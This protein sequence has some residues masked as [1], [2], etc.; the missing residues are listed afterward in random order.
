[1]SHKLGSYTLDICACSYYIYL[2]IRVKSY[3]R[4]RLAVW[5]CLIAHLENRPTSDSS[6]PR[7]HRFL[8]AHHRQA[9]QRNHR[10]LSPPP[11]PRRPRR[12]LRHST[13]G[14]A[15]ARGIAR[16][17]APPPLCPPPLPRD[18]HGKVGAT[19]SRPPLLPPLHSFLWQAFFSAPTERL[20]YSCRNPPCLRSSDGLHRPRP[21]P[22]PR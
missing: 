6:L 22:R 11:Y 8:P 20:G 19:A 18:D 15:G 14:H 7:P 10:Q 2:Y 9:L 13:K 17:S 12:H 5:A 16:E 3:I 21:R 4:F 1:M